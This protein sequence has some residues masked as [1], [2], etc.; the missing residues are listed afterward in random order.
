LLL[1]KLLYLKEKSSDFGEI[2]YSIANLELDDSQ[3]TKYE[4]YLNSRWR[5]ASVLKVIF[6]HNSAVDFSISV[7]YCV[8]KQFFV[9]FG[10]WD[11]PGRIPQNVFFCFSNA[12]LASANGDL[13]IVS[14]TLVA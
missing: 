5:T 12:V 11:I 3:I 8:G 4:F 14:D 10:Q 13:R 6:S 9:E 1:V 2:W 7:K